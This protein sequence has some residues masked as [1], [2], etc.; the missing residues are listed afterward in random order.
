MWVRIEKKE[1]IIGETY[2]VMDNRK[3]V[4]KAVYIGNDEFKTSIGTI[5]KGAGIWV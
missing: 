4:A 5:F 3:F 2:E 1:L